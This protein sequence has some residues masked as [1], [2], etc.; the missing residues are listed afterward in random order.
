M[1][2]A[3]IIPKPVNPRVRPLCLWMGEVDSVPAAGDMLHFSHE[4]DGQFIV[5]VI[6]IHFYLDGPTEKRS[7]VIQTHEPLGSTYWIEHVEREEKRS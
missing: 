5:E 7:I 3:K 1:I 2:R 4:E 6:R